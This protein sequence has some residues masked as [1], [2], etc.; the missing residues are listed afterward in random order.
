[1]VRGSEQ[2]NATVVGPTI[3]IYS[4]EVDVP[5]PAG[6]EGEAGV[7]E[8]PFES[9]DPPSRNVPESDGPQGWLVLFLVFL[10]SA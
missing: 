3:T 2:E 8:N 1:M 7:Q 5:Q 4:A 9:G 6:R 10:Q